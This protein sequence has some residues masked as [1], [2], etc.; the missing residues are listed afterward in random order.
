LLESRKRS[1]EADR[2]KLENDIAEFSEPSDE[3]ESEER[4]R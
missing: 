4:K 2:M 3:E 1:L